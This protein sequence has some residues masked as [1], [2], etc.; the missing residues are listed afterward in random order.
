MA[1]GAG[2]K[3]THGLEHSVRLAS[4][5]APLPRLYRR[6]SVNISFTYG[7]REC[8]YGKRPIGHYIL[9]LEQRTNFT[10]I[11]IP[12]HAI[13]VLDLPVITLLTTAID[14]TQRA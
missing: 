4:I 7:E 8:T 6:V 13:L 9:L 2:D 10:G 14:K 1:L 11:N 3:R 12:S 5:A